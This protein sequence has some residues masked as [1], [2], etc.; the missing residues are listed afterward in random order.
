MSTSEAK[1]AKRNDFDEEESW[2]E[3]NCSSN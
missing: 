2:R 3:G 1:E